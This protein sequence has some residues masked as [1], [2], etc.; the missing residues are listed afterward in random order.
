MSVDHT[1]LRLLGRSAIAVAALAGALAGGPAPAAVAACPPDDQCTSL[2]NVNAGRVLLAATLD[3]Y[4]TDSV[5]TAHDHVLR[6]ENALVAEGYLTSAW[7]D[8]YWG[9]T[10]T[11]AWA[12]FEK[13]VGQNGVHTRN[14]IPSPWEL[15]QLG[16]NRFDTV[17]SYDVGKRITLSKAPGGLSN[18]GTDVVNERTRDMFVEARALLT[19]RGQDN[20][21]KMI[22]T[23]GG[24]CGASC[25]STSHGTHNGGGIIDVRITDYAG[26]RTVIDNRL[27][28]LRD[29]GF[30]AWERSDHIHAVAVNDYQMAWTVHGD[31]TPPANVLDQGYP[32]GYCQIYE[33]TFKKDGLGNC[34]DR[35]P[36]SSPQ[37]TVVTWEDYQAAQG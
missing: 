26:N 15:R 7:A 28:A 20:A 33:W 2:P 4:R 23:Q 17:G 12:T 27:Q 30:A 25:A 6:V 5:T 29:V 9:T 37:R 11:A 16:G 18:D 1:R 35:V 24:Y 10:T 36:S 32:R 19:R 21:A 3:P 13:A 34:D 8:G 22:I 14:G 31:T